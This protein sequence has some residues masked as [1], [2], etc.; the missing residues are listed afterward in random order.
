MF[1]V[2]RKLFGLSTTTPT[3]IATRPVTSTANLIATSDASLPNSGSFVFAD[4]ETTGLNQ[5]GTDE[6]LEIAIIDADGTALLN[7]LVRPVRNTAWP[8]AQAIHGISLQD[9]TH[10]L[11]WGELLPKIATVCAGKTVVFYNAPFDTSF[12]PTGFFPSVACAMRRFSELSPA[13]NARV[14]LADA[15][16]ASGYVS[17]GT[18]HRALEDALACRHIWLYGI[19]ALE[20]ESLPLIDPQITAEMDLETGRRIPLMF[21]TLVTEELEFLTVGSRCNLWT[22]DDRNE[23]NVYRPQSVGGS[24]RIATLSKA[25]NPELSERLAAGDKIQIRLTERNK[26][27]LRFEVLSVKMPEFT[28]LPAT[29]VTFSP[30]DDDILRCFIAHQSGMCDAIGTWEEFQKVEDEIS[31]I[32]KDRGGRYY[33][34]KAKGAKFAIIFS[35]YSRTANEVWRLQQAGYK[36]TTF[37]RAVVHFGLSHL[38]DCPRYLAHVDFLKDYIHNPV[39]DSPQI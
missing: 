32:C 29:P 24:G 31:R 16:T 27:V 21:K 15:A 34:S 36:V 22:K 38:W 8:D 25:A 12:F 20:K 2:L 3:A 18:Y 9:V 39:C 35:P 5:G 6:V 23:I 7:T 17:K 1:N 28:A 19:P 30:I 14:K 4:L 10:V 13:G 37:D 26:N 33:K 11:T